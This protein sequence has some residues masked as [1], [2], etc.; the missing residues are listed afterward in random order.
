MGANGL[1]LST[2]LENRPLAPDVDGLQFPAAAP[3]GPGVSAIGARAEQ[4]GAR[5]ALKETVPEP[6][7]G[8]RARRPVRSGRVTESRTSPNSAAAGVAEGTAGGVAASTGAGARHSAG[9]GGRCN[10]QR[11]CGWQPG[12]ASL[13]S[14]SMAAKDYGASAPD[15]RAGSN[16]SHARPTGRRNPDAARDAHPVATR[17]CNA[18]GRSIWGVQ[19]AP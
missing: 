18:A 10:R 4:G 9:A 16:R 1:V 8:V 3:R 14:G 5:R 11:R 6:P 12:G 19:A 13:P 15:G 17:H 7:R 2:S